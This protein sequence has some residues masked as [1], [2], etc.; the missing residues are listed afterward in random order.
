MNPKRQHAVNRIQNMLT[1]LRGLDSYLKTTLPK[2]HAE[3]AQ[4]IADAG[5]AATDLQRAV[6]ASLL[7]HLGA[8]AEG[9]NDKNKL[10]RVRKDGV[11]LPPKK[12]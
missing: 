5:T 2:V 4:Q 10:A 6:E 3:I 9:P 1:E 8:H 12:G 11:K 7:K